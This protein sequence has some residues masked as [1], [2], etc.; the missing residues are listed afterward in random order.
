M[1]V[2]LFE[3]VYLLCLLTLLQTVKLLKSLIVCVFFSLGLRG[4][5]K[6]P[7]TKEKKTPAETERSRQWRANLKDNKQQYESHKIADMERNERNRQLPVSDEEAQRRRE[8][9]SLRQQ[10][11]R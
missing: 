9:A 4:R 10:R 11:R 7:V 1:S 2:S 6:V 5:I 8:M 3:P